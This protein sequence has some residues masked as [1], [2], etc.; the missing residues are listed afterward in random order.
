MLGVRWERHPGHRG[1]DGAPARCE[2]VFMGHYRIL[3]GFLQPEV[4]SNRLRGLAAYAQHEHSQA[5]RAAGGN[6][7]GA[8]WARAGEALIFFQTRACH[9]RSRPGAAIDFVCVGRHR[10]GAG[11]ACSRV[12]T[13]RPGCRG[14]WHE[15]YTDSAARSLQRRAGRIGILSRTHRAVTPTRR[16]AQ[17]VTLGV[18]ESR[19]DRASCFLF[20]WPRNP[21]LA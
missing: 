14:A 8:S 6:L 13:G 20:R 12:S 4:P 3:P 18:H 17:G 7:G 15:V 21:G 19:R 1:P 9:Q 16:L 11:D 10:R 5:L 2:N